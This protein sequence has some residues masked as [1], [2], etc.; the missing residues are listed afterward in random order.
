MPQ[1]VRHAPAHLFQA[2]RILLKPTL[3]DLFFL[4]LMLS[5]F[6]RPQSWQGLLADGDTGWHIRTGDYILETRRVPLEDLF[7]FSRAGQPWFAWEWLADVSFALLHRWHG[8]EA[9][10][11]FSA[12]VLCLSAA[13]LLCWLLGRGVGLWIGVAVVLGTFSESSI[14]SLARPHIYSLLFVTLALWAL[15]E[16]RRRSGPLLWALVPLSALWA[17]LHAG[18]VSWLA[19]LA[20]LVGLSCLERNWAALRRYGVL[21]GLCS[22]ATL[23]NPYGWHL[24][25]HIV[26]Y[27]VRPGSSTTYGNFSLP[28]SAPKTWLSSPSCCSWE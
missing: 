16:D 28:A 10:A 17:N 23:L 4:I 25:Q 9:V 8:L 7:S 21:A 19:I 26:R 3:V 24:H 15:D 6:G 18:F 14:H 5:A 11:A 27:L 13:F 2:C 12:C 1:A 20:L 22:A